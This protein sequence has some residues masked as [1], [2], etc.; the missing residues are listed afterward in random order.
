[1]STN[2]ERE[3]KTKTEEEESRKSVFESCGNESGIVAASLLETCSNLNL[4][5]AVS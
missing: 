5:N 1:M 3:K 4:I 2:Y